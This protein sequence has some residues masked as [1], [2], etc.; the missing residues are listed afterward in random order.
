MSGTDSH[1][2]APELILRVDGSKSDLPS[3]D[4][5]PSNSI[6]PYQQRKYRWVILSLFVLYSASN[7]LQWT[8][9]AIISDV[10]T[11]YYGVPGT[12]VSWTSMVYMLTY[13]PLVFPACWLL[14][15]TVSFMIS[16]FSVALS[17][18]CA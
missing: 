12:V 17:L 2:F 18:C 11:R 15:K 9:Y 1:I 5:S 13:V 8:Q 3:M 4:S 14:D 16:N 6:L 10:V 7:S